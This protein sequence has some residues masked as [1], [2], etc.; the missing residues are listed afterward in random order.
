M[1]KKKKYGF[2]TI[3]VVVAHAVKTLDTVVRT[4]LILKFIASKEYY[5]GVSV[6]L[7]FANELYEFHTI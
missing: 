4:A 2:D 5:N 6:S 1:C 7:L 3:L